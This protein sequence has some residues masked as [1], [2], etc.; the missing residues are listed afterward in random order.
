MNGFLAVLL[1]GALLLAAP[2]TALPAGPAAPGPPPADSLTIVPTPGGPA[3]VLG[4]PSGDLTP[5]ATLVPTLDAPADAGGAA[6]LLDVPYRSQFDGSPY[7]GAN[8]GPASL[9]MV[10]EAYGIELP[11][12]RLRD[13]ANGIQG[14]SGYPD[15]VAIE[16]LQAIALD[17]GLQVVGLYG[18]DHRY[19]RWTV[20]GVRRQVE[21]GWPV[22]TL[23]H[24][25]SLPGHETS[26]SAADHYVVVV[27][28]TPD[29]FLV[30]D[31]A[32]PGQA[33]RLRPLSTEQLRRAWDDSSVPGQAIAVGPGEGRLPLAV[34]QLLASE[35]AAPTPL[36]EVAAAQ[37][38]PP[39]LPRPAAG[40]TRKEGTP[41]PT[42]TPRP[43]RTPA[44]GRWLHGL[45]PPTASA[46]IAPPA[47]RAPV[48]PDLAAP[49][50]DDALVLAADAGQQPNHL[51]ALG[52]A[53]GVAAAGALVL[54]RRPDAPEPGRR[55]MRGMRS[56]AVEARII[57]PTRKGA[58]HRANAS[59][60]PVARGLLVEAQ[61]G[62]P[63]EGVA[64][65][66]SVATPSLLAALAG[67]PDPR[68]RR[69]QRYGVASLLVLAA[70]AVLCGARSPRAIARWGRECGPEARRALGIERDSSP[71]AAT[72][73]RLFQALDREA[74][75]VALVA[76]VERLGPQSDGA[77]PWV[78]ALGDGSG[79]GC[80][81]ADEDVVAML[82][83]LAAVLL[84]G[85]GDPGIAAHPEEALA[86][87]G[88][89]SKQ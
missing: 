82:R 15:G 79:A 36:P 73:R 18:A 42:P 10:L 23:V 39:P 70:C 9:A 4:P 1:A 43:T 25:R 76:W 81:G 60:A 71:A 77:A 88:L 59:L 37:P 45:A 24:Y 12:A 65:Q 74:V 54:R 87:V 49:T 22:L 63:A 89:A 80:E 40:A 31:P 78:S 6:L 29:G 7:A 53:L 20:E 34:A 72:F 27:G 41:Q 75:R 3:P 64:G 83:G 57:A 48:V 62:T 16:S 46:R 30:H 32:F 11:T 47:V 38:P 67:L 85:R 52:I 50:T 8:C 66:P 86:L 56:G 2:P 61:D 19:A 33:G 5:E 13:L 55:A 84:G 28:V 51:V 35:L 14:T 26:T 17:A 44:P 68:K 58:V 21:R 69:G